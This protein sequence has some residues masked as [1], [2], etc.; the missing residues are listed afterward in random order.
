MNIFT[1]DQKARIDAV[2]N[3]SIRRVQLRTSNACSPPL[4][5]TQQ[6]FNNSVRIY[7]N[8]VSTV[9]NYFINNN[10]EV[11]TILINDISGKVIF[12]NNN[13][14]VPSQIDVSNLS[15]GVYFI[16]FKSDTSLVTKK[17]I[18]E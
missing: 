5:I 12:R 15:S 9:L 18:K 13:A 6:S 17:F 16:T 3:N 10:F 14:V 1:I 7:P 8:P 2:M 4:S 11:Q